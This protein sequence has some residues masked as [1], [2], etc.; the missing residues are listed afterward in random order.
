MSRE[1]SAQV[2]G[3]GAS[4][5]PGEV[6]LSDLFLPSRR[7]RAAP[8]P[9]GHDAGEGGWFSIMVDGSGDGHSIALFPGEE[10]FFSYERG[11]SNNDAEF[12]AVILALENLPDHARAR[13]HTDSQVVVWHLAA[14]SPRRP[15]TYAR[16]KARIQDLIATKDLEVEFRWIPRREN[17]ADRFLK[18]YIASLCGAGGAEPLHRRVR[19]LE[20]ENLRLKARL[21]KA[22]KML[23]NRP[24]VIRDAGG[25][26]MVPEQQ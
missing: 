25:Y 2:P 1:H 16:K 7:Y 20:V 21:A 15:A 19:R 5:S 11:A 24:V 17:R 10:V 14:V 13:I 12:N 8:A 3:T 4:P 6:F 18:N 9:S 22:M 23:E 26:G